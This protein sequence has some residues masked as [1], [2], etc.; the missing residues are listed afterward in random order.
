MANRIAFWTP[1]ASFVKAKAQPL[2]TRSTFAG[3]SRFK[4]GPAKFSGQLS[5]FHPAAPSF[6]LGD[7]KKSPALLKGQFNHIGQSLDVGGQ[8]DPWTVSVPSISF[9]KWLHSFDWL[10]DLLSPKKGAGK[11]RAA[12]YVDSWIVT[13]GKWNDFSWQADILGRRLFNWLTL[14]SEA[15]AQD[16]EGPVGRRRRSAVYRQLKVLKANYKQ[17]SSGLNRMRAAAALAM[18][19][20]KLVERA[21]G[22]LA[23][24]LDL[25]DI[26]IEQQI[27]ADGGH[28]SRSPENTLEALKILLALDTLLQ[29]RGVEGSRLMSRAIDRLTPMIAFFQHT[30]GT[31]ASFHGSGEGDLA[32]TK[33]LLAAAPSE[34]KPFGYCP[35][36]GYQRIGS[37]QTVVIVDTGSTPP[38]PF[39]TQTHMAPLSFELSTAHGRMIVNCGWNEMQTRAWQRPVRAAAAHSTLILNNHSSGKLLREGWKTKILGQAVQNEAGPVKAQRKEQ[40]SGTWLETSHDGYRGQYGL[41]HRRRF[42]VSA[43]GDDVRGEDSLYVPL[44]AQPIRRDEI[45]FDIRFHFH[46]DVRVSLSQD[47]RSALLVIGGKSGWRF[48]TDGGLIRVEPSVYLGAGH[49]PIKTQQLVISGKAYGDSDGES[50]SNRVRWSLRELKSRSS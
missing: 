21:D 6:K 46:P 42:F 26:E 10:Q 11:S 16:S 14:W 9:A 27:L 19:G 18:G 32:F 29:D 15:L 7:P 33:R 1:Y 40:V 24:G 35:H 23:R 47:Q 5:A 41:S 25:L 8:G 39:D 48:R 4:S 17:T 37:G 28:I 49:K 22:F 45:P 34:A 31:L 44:G 20:A 30:D 43:E 38:R 2:L 50:R 36:T 13:Y 12:G 3:A